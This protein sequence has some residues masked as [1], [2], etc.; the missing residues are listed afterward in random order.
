MTNRNAGRA[1]DLVSR[2]LRGGRRGRGPRSRTRWSGRVRDG[3]NGRTGIRGGDPAGGRDGGL[4][5]FRAHVDTDPAENLGDHLVGRRGKNGGSGEPGGASDQTGDRA[6]GDG[7]GSPPDAPA[8]RVGPFQHGGSEGGANLALPP[9]LAGLGRPRS[10]QEECGHA[11]AMRGEEGHDIAP[12]AAVGQ[13][14]PT[15]LRNRVGGGV[16]MHI[17]NPTL[18]GHGPLHHH[19]RSLGILRRR[20]LIG[21]DSLEGEGEAPETPVAEHPDGT[22]GSPHDLR[23][24]GN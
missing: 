8:S 3:G 4:S 23:D 13:R 17:R 9:E 20:L 6:G 19:F 15:R 5:G 24:R 1:L 10:G 11:A 7:D 22:G 2:R 14:R 16:A 12:D 18:A 21:N